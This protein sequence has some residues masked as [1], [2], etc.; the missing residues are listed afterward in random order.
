[1]RAHLE[2]EKQ[3]PKVMEP[4]K[5]EFWKWVSWAELTSSTKL[6]NDDPLFL[7]LLSLQKTR[8]DFDP[9]K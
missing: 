2:D 5:C 8:A 4:N 7:P 3:E 1:M 9:T 6:Y